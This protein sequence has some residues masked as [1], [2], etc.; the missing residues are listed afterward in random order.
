MSDKSCLGE[1][2]TLLNCNDLPWEDLAGKNIFITGGTGLVGSG[3]IRGLLHI[4]SEKNLNLKIFALVRSIGKAQAMLP[5]DE[6]LVLA[7]GSLEQLPWIYDPIH[8]V[9]HAASPTAS[10]YFMEHPVE[11]VKAAVCGTMNILDL[12][13][14]KQVQS[15]VYLSS[16]EV[17]GENDTDEPLS[18]DN[19]VSAKPI[20]VRSCYPQSKLLCEN[21]CVDY[22][23]EYG[24]SCKAIRLAQTFGPGVPK[25]D[26]RVFAQFAR[27]AIQKTDIVLQTPGLTKQTYLYTMDAVTAILTVLLKGT[28]GQIYNAAN[29]SNYCSIRQMAELVAQEL[30]GGEI[31]VTVN[32]SPEAAAKYPPTHKWNLSAEKLIALGWKPTADLAYMYRR[33]IEDLRGDVKTC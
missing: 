11:T 29:P 3:L 15:L 8:Y 27:S 12:A 4:N 21:L 32:T 28:A 13:K 20:S 23:H 25:N 2:E 7:E 19:A 16:M 1:C 26:N 22:A 30:A 17:Y 6:A 5:Q 9:V 31:S 18:E 33:L 14:E 24:I 10:S